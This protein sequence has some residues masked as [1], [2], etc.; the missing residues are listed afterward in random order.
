M[1]FV[2]NHDAEYIGNYILNTVPFELTRDVDNILLSESANRGYLYFVNRFLQ[3]GATPAFN[4]NE[5]ILF[6]DSWLIHELIQVQKTIESAIWHGN[7]DIVNM[8]LEDP[9]VIQLLVIMYGT[10]LH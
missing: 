3:R 7:I 1:S 8:L 4:D 9:R 2:I 5:L 10:E 6:D